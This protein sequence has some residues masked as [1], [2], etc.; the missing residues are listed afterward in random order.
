[1]LQIETNGLLGLP[2]NKKGRMRTR[3]GIRMRPQG[4]CG[5]N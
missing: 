1:M 4:V 5:G 2:K 3:G